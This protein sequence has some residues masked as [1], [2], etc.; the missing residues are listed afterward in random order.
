MSVQTTLFKMKYSDFFSKNFSQN[1]HLLLLGCTGLFGRHLLPRLKSS[2]DRNGNCPLITLVTRSRKN[3]LEK[4]PYLT[5]INIIENDF[6]E[7][8]QIN[9]IQ[10]PTHV[11]HMANISAT[12]TFNGS[13]Q[14]SKYRLLINSIEFLRKVVKAGVTKRIIFT[15]SGVAYGS[16]D[17]Y[18]ESEPSSID[19]FNPAYSLGFAKLNA[20]YLLNMLCQEIGASLSVCRCFSF[21]SPYLPCNIHYALGNFVYSAIKKEDIIITGD[22]LDCR[23]YQHVEDTIDWLIYLLNTSDNV[24]IINFGSENSISIKD[25]ACLVRDLICPEI[26][27]NIQNLPADPHNFRRKNYVPSLAMSK[28]LG[29][30]NRRTLKSSI[31]ELGSFIR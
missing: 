4:F 21:V 28:I 22:G 26:S 12:D 30:E 5:S 7:S 24:P 20:E 14:Y 11:L 3:T 2:L 13:S 23:S 18:I 25:L 27:V 10:T 16:N 29:L 15:S 19:V 31:I 17:S 6:L 8:N 9:F 1:D